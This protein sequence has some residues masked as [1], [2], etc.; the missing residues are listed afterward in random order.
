MKVLVIGGGGFIGCNVAAYHLN[1]GDEVTLFDNFSRDGT[2]ANLKWISSLYPKIKVVKGD[3]TQPNLKF[4]QIISHTDLIYH[5]A[6][7]VA[8]T[9]SVKDPMQDFRI[10]ALGTLNILE[11]IRK[12]SKDPI[13]IFASTNKVYGKLNDVKVVEDKTRYRFHSLKQGVAES[14]NLDFYSPYGCSKGAADQYVL[15]Y[16]RIYGLKT[17]VFRQSCI[18]GTRQFG[19][20]DQ[21]SVSYTHL[22]LPTILRV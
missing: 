7:Q 15:D 20:E 9:T 22:T 17:I 12:S 10:N 4:L 16:A 14:Q 18:Y 5:L 8:V 3:I 13:L 6:A 2:K 1:K 21:G 11:A 19:M